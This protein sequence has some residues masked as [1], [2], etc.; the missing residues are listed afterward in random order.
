MPPR[1]TSFPAQIASEGQDVTLACE[2]TAD[3]K[4]HLSIRKVTGQITYTEGDND[5]G[6]IQLRVVGDNKL[7]LHITKL[8]PDD[9]GNYE[10][11]AHNE[12][13]HATAEMRLTVQCG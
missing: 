9:T 4:A 10:C 12:G 3:P 2:V 6:R 1:V 5:G 8:K 11:E 7:E 13:G